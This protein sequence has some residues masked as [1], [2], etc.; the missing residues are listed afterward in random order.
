M[1]VWDQTA[2][3]FLSQMFL[4]VTVAISAPRLCFDSLEF[5]RADTSGVSRYPSSVETETYLE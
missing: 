2:I 3:I 1:K 5:E 4:S